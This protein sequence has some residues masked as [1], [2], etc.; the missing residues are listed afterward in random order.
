MDFRSLGGIED[1]GARL[2]GANHRDWSKVVGGLAGAVEVAV[3]RNA[4]AHGS[5]TIDSSAHA[6]LLAAGARPSP[7]GS[8]VSLAYSELREFRGRLLNLLNAAGI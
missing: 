2:L 5:R 3:V 1:W 7:V 4:F 8:T 6:R